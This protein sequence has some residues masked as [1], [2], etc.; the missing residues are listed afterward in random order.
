M[1]AAATDSLVG[2]DGNDT[3][4]GSGGIGTTMNGG[5][6]NDLYV[7]ERNAYRR[8]GRHADTAGGIDR[9]LRQP[10]ATRLSR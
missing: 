7:V 4:N 5:F 8:G 6:G 3:L 9:V 1:A 2:G 10:R